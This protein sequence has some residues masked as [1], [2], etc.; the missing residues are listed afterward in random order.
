MASA[1]ERFDVEEVRNEVSK[2]NNEFVFRGKKLN[3]TKIH[4]VITVMFSIKHPT[5]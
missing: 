1:P 5:V 4:Q 3:V 2:V